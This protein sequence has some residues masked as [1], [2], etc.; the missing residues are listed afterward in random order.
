MAK[1]GVSGKRSSFSLRRLD[2]GK[3]RPEL[4]RRRR[5]VRDILGGTVLLG[6]GRALRRRR[7]PEQ[8]PDTTSHIDTV[9]RIRNV[10]DN[11]GPSGAGL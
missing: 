8:G 3:Q 9:R 5:H 4:V 10:G 7:R 6:T 2:Y 11:D 1:T